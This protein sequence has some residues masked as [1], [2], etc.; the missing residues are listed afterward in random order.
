MM[1]MMMPQRRGAEAGARARRAEGRAEAPHRKREE[2]W[3]WQECKSEMMD[4]Q[5]ESWWC[6]M[7]ATS[8]LDVAPRANSALFM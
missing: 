6:R 3:G 2:N 1:M 5:E 7:D 4:F 8:H